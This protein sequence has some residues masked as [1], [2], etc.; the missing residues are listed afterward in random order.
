MAASFGGLSYFEY[1]PLHEANI[2]PAM[3]DVRHRGIKR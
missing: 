1:P 3:T 2:D